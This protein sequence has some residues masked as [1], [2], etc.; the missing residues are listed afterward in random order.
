MFTA[1]LAAYC[2]ECSD[3]GP[4]SEL[5]YQ[6]AELALLV[7]C[8]G[9]NTAAT[10]QLP[11]KPHQLQSDV[12]KIPSAQERGTEPSGLRFLPQPLRGS[13]SSVQERQ[14][15]RGIL[16]KR[17]QRWGSQAPAQV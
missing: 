17:A 10:A 12:T 3:L 8:T 9:Q 16:G 14:R 11:N 4:S 15:F 2:Q 7:T 5:K 6:T 13:R 1:V